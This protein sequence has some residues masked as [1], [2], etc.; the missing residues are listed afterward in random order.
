MGKKGWTLIEIVFHF[1]QMESH[2][3]YGLSR[4]YTYSSTVQQSIC[5]TAFPFLDTSIK[6]S[7]IIVLHPDSRYAAFRTKTM[8]YPE[9]EL[10]VL[11][12]V[13]FAQHRNVKA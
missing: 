6:L 12:L 11:I 8:R 3:T 5:L 10:L 4:I 2:K 9:T 13:Y 1:C 7:Y